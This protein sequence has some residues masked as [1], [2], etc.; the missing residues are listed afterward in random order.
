MTIDGLGEAAAKVAGSVGPSMVRLGNGRGGNG[1][2]V[3][4]DRILTN[5]HNLHHHGDTIGLRF[6][7]GRRDE[8]TVEGVDGDGDIAVLAA[9]TGAAPAIGRADDAPPLGAVV[10]GVGLSRRGPR[11]TFGLVSATDQ[12]MHGPHGRRIRGAI[13]HTAPLVR[14]SS[15]SA[16]VDTEGRLLGINTTRLGS[17]FYQ[18]LPADDSLWAR[19]ER[20]GGGQSIERPRIGVAVAPSWMAKRMRAAVG[21][22]ERD[23]LL[24]REVLDDSPAE[25]AGLQTG[26][27]LVSAGGTGLVEPED[28]AD[29]IGAAGATLALGLVRGETDVEVEI[30]LEAGSKD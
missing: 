10:F 24:V 22:P 18:A 14:G 25:R 20:L 28:L 12:A 27:L 23:G 30:D 15:G 6:A 5:A 16:L 26:D 4:K 11:I 17:G 13:E 1:V 9:D 3:G 2:V 7:D 19:V 29:A 8:A 21:L